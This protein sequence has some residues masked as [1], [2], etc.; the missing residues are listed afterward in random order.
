M[1]AGE[2]GHMILD[3][4][5]AAE[6]PCGQYGCFEALASRLSIARDLHQIKTKSTASLDSLVWD[7]RNLGSN[8]IAFHYKQGDPDA[9]AIVNSAARVCGK[10]A[11]SL[12]N[13]FNPE[14]IVFSGGFILQLGDEFLIPV[15]EE[16]SKCMDAVYSFGSEKVPIKIGLLDNAMLVGGC[17]MVREECSEVREYGKER[18]MA[19]VVDGIDERELILLQSV[20]RHGAPLPISRDPGSDLHA[21]SLR[22][23]RNRGLIRTEAGQSLGRSTQVEITDLGRI[24][25][26][27][28]MNVLG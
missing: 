23:L 4:N 9:V 26:E 6:C 16:A 7:E 1:A 3:A 27:E 28:N 15:R 18:I 10:A 20:H 11:F 13:V 2:V 12:L 21:D 8:E 5:S 25:V 17:R 22:S 24:I 14:I 19:A